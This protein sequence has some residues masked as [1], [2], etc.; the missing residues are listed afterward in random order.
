MKVHNWI[1]ANDWLNGGRNKNLRPLYHAGLFVR[2]LIEDDPRSPIGVGWYYKQVR[3]DE[4]R[5]NQLTI[6]IYNVDGTATLLGTNLYPSARRA[7]MEYAGV[8]G[9][10]K[11]K[12]KLYFRQ[13]TDEVISKRRTPCKRCQGMRTYIYRDDN[14]NLITENCFACY[15]GY[16]KSTTAYKSFVWPTQTINASVHWNPDPYKY[17][18]YVPLLVDP[19]TGIIL[20]VGSYTNTQ[21]EHGVWEVKVNVHHNGRDNQY[22][23]RSF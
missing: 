10:H 20:G 15:D 17:E 21:N 1:T 9:T 3:D 23:D 13:V 7:M 14:D 11:R 19:S 6:L 4:R 2:R 18:A 22:D 12:G 5:L 16:N 8:I